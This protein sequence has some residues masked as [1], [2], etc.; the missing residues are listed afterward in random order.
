MRPAPA[1]KLEKNFVLFHASI[2]RNHL[3]SE[4][5]A[6]TGLLALVGWQHG[7]DVREQFGKF[8]PTDIEN[9]GGAPR[10]QNEVLDR[11]RFRLLENRA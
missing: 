8:P 11:T 2:A 9:A 7:D 1:F 3:D 10:G 5:I 4:E 6:K